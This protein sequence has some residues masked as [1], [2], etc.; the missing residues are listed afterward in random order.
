[1][2]RDIKI[3]NKNFLTEN[4]FIDKRLCDEDYPLHFHEFYEVEYIYSGAGRVYINNDVY[5]ISGGNTI[6]MMPNDLERVEVIEPM[7]L[8]NINFPKNTIQPTLQHFLSE[9]TVTSAIPEAFFD[10]IFNENKLN[11]PFDS[12]YME[13]IINCIL[14]HII[15]NTQLKSNPSLQKNSK[16][17]K[18]EISQIV[19]SY[20]RENFRDEISLEILAKKFNYSQNHLSKNF[21]ELF[22]KTITEYTRDFRLANSLNLLI[23]TDKSV[24][25]ICFEVGFSSFSNFLRLFKKK[26]HT[27]PGQLRKKGIDEITEIISKQ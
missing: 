11:S 19:A 12:L 25:D 3:E 10:A 26:Y 4:I 1:M 15:R 20:I 16:K 27:S 21:C 22:G 13:N 23:N 7:I 8:L 18:L 17:N 24:T 14:I 2:K 5:D 9:S 6:F